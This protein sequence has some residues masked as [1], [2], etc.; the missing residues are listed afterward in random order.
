MSEISAESTT[1]PQPPV[2][3]GKVKSTYMAVGLLL[4]LISGGAGA[5]W[6][7]VGASSTITALE[8]AAAIAHER[9]SALQARA[10]VAAAETALESQDVDSARKHLDV[11]RLKLS[12]A[13]STGSHLDAGVM[14]TI[15]ERL[16]AVSLSA[17]KEI[18]RADTVLDEI[19]L[20]LDRE[21][22]RSN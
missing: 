1:A 21:L 18:E 7:Y 20:A 16:A 10:A 22:I 15:S 5:L 8:S 6:V 19:G 14:A 11:A 9:D 2:A 12:E 13:S 3:L 17:A 4:G